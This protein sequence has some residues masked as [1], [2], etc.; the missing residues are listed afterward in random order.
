VQQASAT[1][2]LT[3]V[4]RALSAVPGS[5]IGH[6]LLR[7]VYA[8]TALQLAAQPPSDVFFCY[9]AAVPEAPY[10]A[11]PVQFD[12]DAAMPVRETVPGLGHAL[13]LRAYRT[14]D[15]LQLDWWYDSR[16]LDRVTVEE[17]A[18]QFPLALIELT[19]E[20]IPAVLDAT[21]I[22]A[23]SGT[24]DPAEVCPLDVAPL[25]GRD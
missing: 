16:R 22:A 13:Q 9:L 2:T 15:V 17:L 1:T 21:G 24:L 12:T 6:G 19:S 18:E 14:G 4:R 23:E 8:P 25:T 10:G 20:A 11:G 7:Y 3:D 5:A